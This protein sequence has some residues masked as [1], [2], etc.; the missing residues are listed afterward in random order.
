MRVTVVA[1]LLN[2]SLLSSP[3]NGEPEVES[4]FAADLMSDVLALARPGSLLLT[5]LTNPQVVRTSE[6][7][8]VAAIV[9]VRGKH[10]PPDTVEMARDA[11]IPLLETQ[12][13]LFEACGRLYCAGI[14]GCDPANFSPLP[15]NREA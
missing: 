8:G 5:G 1:Q 2:G 11:G 12:F 4:A 9:F 3:R 13:T 6:V 10:A 7:A 15:A 14:R